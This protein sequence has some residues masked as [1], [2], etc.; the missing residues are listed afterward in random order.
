MKL[1]K[2]Q[3]SSESVKLFKSMHHKSHWKVIKITTEK[4]NN[5]KVQQMV[6][7]C[8]L[9]KTKIHKKREPKEWTVWGVYRKLK[10]KRE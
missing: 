6:A 5:Q 9:Q 4:K 2:I 3:N 8:C 1:K 10:K 7:R